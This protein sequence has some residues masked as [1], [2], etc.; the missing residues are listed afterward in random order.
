[1]SGDDVLTR[2]GPACGMDRRMRDAHRLHRQ[3]DVVDLEELTAEY[4]MID[5]P[6]RGP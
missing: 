1:M 2:V 3:G 4:E 6:F 5:P